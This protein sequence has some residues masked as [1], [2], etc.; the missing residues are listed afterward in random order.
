MP[1]ASIRAR[2]TV[3]Y[4]GVLLLTLLGL[5]VA[6]SLL[7]AR[8]SLAR[9]DGMLD[10]EFREAAE[11]L[12]SGRPAASLAEEPSAFRETYLLRVLDERGRTLTENPR[13]RDVPL[14][15]PPA[16]S[17][18]HES[19]VPGGLGPCRVV[20]GETATPEGRRVLQIATSLDAW[21]EELA[22]LRGVLLT[23]LPVGLVAATLGGYWLAAASLAPIGRMTET[24]RRVSAENLG[25]RLA[26]PNPD[27]ELG[28]L[29]ATLNAMLDRIDRGFE[30]ARRFTADAA[31]ELKTPVA[32]IRS[33]AEVTLLSPRPP[34]E[35][36]RALRSIVEE[37][38]RL[39][40]LAD[41]LLVLSRADAGATGETRPVRLDE[42]VRDAAD[43]AREAAR[44]GG[45]DLRVEAL[46]A[47]VVEADPDALRQVFD[48][49]LDNAVKY[50]P[51]G[52]RI[53]VRGRRAGGNAVVEVADT[54]EGI[55]PEALPRVFDRFYRADPSRSR[56]TGGV[57][58]GLSIARAVAERQGGAVEAE[59]V[60]G[61][62][63]TFR[64]TLPA[65]AET[66][67]AAGFERS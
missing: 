56:R 67:P 48:N 6:V 13:L 21:R 3:W 24:A 20:A 11:L 39:G 63:S 62:G 15:L 31:H 44:R 16:G 7:M 65:R 12:A 25:E 58:L 64:V 22:E 47:A 55:P 37:T 54:G 43:A 50:T 1:R 41:R 60:P 53:A 33:E 23:I 29:A 46:P 27:D 9:V 5:G 30:A 52:G 2:L 61:A 36:Q 32:N 51:G 66:G 59:S 8:A 4:G 18:L 42:V 57:G 28:R 34:D 40:R 35:Y 14:P 38:T 17:R 26:A 45:I 10:F 19:V 49:L